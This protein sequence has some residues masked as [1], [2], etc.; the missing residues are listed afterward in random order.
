M[1]GVKESA[2]ITNSS[3]WHHG[4]RG[5]EFPQDEAE[6]ILLLAA[7][8]CDPEFD[9]A[10]AL[11]KVENAY[12]RYEPNE[13]PEEEGE[14]AVGGKQADRVIKLAMADAKV[15]FLD[16]YKKPREVFNAFRWR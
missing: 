10:E 16:Q 9:E 11:K 8:H 4:F 3:G 5:E 13:V 15:L 14:D 1:N 6:E 2:G 12:I 7:S